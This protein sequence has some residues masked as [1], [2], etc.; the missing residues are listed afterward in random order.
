MVHFGSMK[1]KAVYVVGLSTKH[2]RTKVLKFWREP[3]IKPLVIVG[4]FAMIFC[5][6]VSVRERSDKNEALSRTQSSRFE[7]EHN[8]LGASGR[9]FRIDR[10][11]VSE[12]LSRWRELVGSH[13]CSGTT[14]DFR[15]FLENISPDIVVS[16]LAHMSA[17]E[18]GCEESGAL[19]DVWASADPAKA[20]LWA[21]RVPGEKARLDLM[22]LAA[23]R[24]AVIDDR[25]AAEW[26]LG[27]PDEDSRIAIAE[28][29]ASESMSQNPVAALDLLSKLPALT[30]K[31]D[32]VPRAAAEW[33]HKDRFRAFE[34]A[35]QI[36]NE[37]LRREVMERIAVASSEH[38]PLAAAEIALNSIAPS[39]ERDRALVLV[40]QRW[41]QID[42]VAASGWVSHLPD[43]VLCNDVVQNMVRFWASSDLTSTSHWVLSLRSAEAKSKAAFAYAKVLEQTDS[44]EAARWLDAALR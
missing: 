36:G 23:Y 26:A 8:D 33:A 5:C 9:K 18:L 12:S 34:W 1:K 7:A 14:P 32:V 42:P 44:I 35:K 2:G 20:A 6:F 4:I 17:T 29:I 31:S 39:P 28:A 38:D 22:R 19:F 21:E 15:E 10:S 16:M 11:G 27:L 13:Q 41:A 37:D 24:W 25:K 40:V 3:V 30:E 43:S